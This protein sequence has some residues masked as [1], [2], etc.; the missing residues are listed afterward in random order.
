MQNDY[1]TFYIVLLTSDMLFHETLQYSISEDINLSNFSEREL[2]LRKFKSM[3]SVAPSKACKKH[4]NWVCVTAKSKTLTLNI[5]AFI[6]TSK[7]F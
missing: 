5:V 1:C 6:I 3:S 2:K 4:L 7:A